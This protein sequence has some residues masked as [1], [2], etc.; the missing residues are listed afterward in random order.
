MSKRAVG[1]PAIVTPVK[2][3]LRAAGIDG[4]L[5]DA[6]EIDSTGARSWKCEEAMS[7]IADTGPIWA[8]A[9]VDVGVP[10]HLKAGSSFLNSKDYFASIVKTIISQQLAT[11]ACNKIHTQA[12]RAFKVPEGSPITPAKV[13]GAEFVLPSKGS[14]VIN[15][16]ES[17]LSRMK[18]KAIQNLAEHFD[19]PE[20]LK[21]V[22]LKS[23]SQEELEEKLSAI[24]GVG[25]WTIN[26]VQLFRLG[27]PDVFAI[28][29]LAV[30]NGI[31]LMLGRPKKA[32]ES[33]SG[34]RELIR[35]VEP[36]KPY[37]SVICMMAYNATDS[38]KEAAKAK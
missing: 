2:K 35:L 24:S 31:A 8:R 17:K 18:F 13:K 38:A 19:D 27:L 15:G 7:H 12:L 5:A 37:R 23:I 20:K 14:V 1:Y 11:S 32:F 29:D 36:L 26:M 21:G 10:K 4:V 6:R 33:D 30:R 22:D 9:V 28:G 3:K 25:P 34:R 16:M